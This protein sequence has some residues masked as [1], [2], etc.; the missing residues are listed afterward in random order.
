[1]QEF[2]NALAGLASFIGVVVLIVIGGPL[3]VAWIGSDSL[4]LIAIFV[5][6]F[7]WRLTWKSL[8]GPDA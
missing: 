6:A 8:E 5:L 1:M 7:V 2:M 3:L 4:W